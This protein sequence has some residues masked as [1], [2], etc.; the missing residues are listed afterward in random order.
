MARRRW[1][2]IWTEK[3][4]SGSTRKELRPDERSIW[5]DFLA[6][7]AD[8]P[9]SGK[10]CLYSGVP[11]TN[12]QLCIMLNITSKQLNSARD[13]FIQYG[14]I[15]MVDSIPVIINWDIY[16]AEFNRTE[17]MREYMQERRK[18]NKNKKRRDVKHS[19]SLQRKSLHSKSQPIEEEEDKEEDKEKKKR[20]RGE[21]TKNGNFLSKKQKPTNQAIVIKY[22][23]ERYKEYFKTEYIV[24]HNKD[25][26]NA[27]RLLSRLSLDE[28]LKRIDM[29]FDYASSDQGNIWWWGEPREFS[30]IVTHINGLVAPP[31]KKGKGKR[32]P[33][34]KFGDGDVPF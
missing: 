29:A 30:D 6:L 18:S 20:E 3:W 32:E 7:A 12:K 25:Y 26:P 27:V 34:Q 33:S 24:K 9:D 8:S 23:E 16:Q 10:V 5:I 21:V 14:K 28:I 15:K 22:F 2:K 31:E 19:K 17:Y 1:F 4:L 11:Y 13:K